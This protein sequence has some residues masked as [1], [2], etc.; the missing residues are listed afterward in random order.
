M[1]AH[2]RACPERKRSSLTRSCAGHEPRS[3][4][5]ARLHAGQAP[6]R[7]WPAESSASPMP[8]RVA[9]AA[10]VP[11]PPPAAAMHTTAV[12]MWMS[13]NGRRHR[14]QTLHASARWHVPYFMMACCTLR[15]GADA[16]LPR[17]ATSVRSFHRGCPCSAAQCT[18]S[19]SQD[20]PP[21]VLPA[22]PRP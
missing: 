11:G 20:A 17:P 14:N 4:A 18:P 16:A 21:V 6:A 5:S 22:R 13:L 8:G 9:T 3:R 7:A 2:V 1:L 19:W 15:A 10:C 12:T